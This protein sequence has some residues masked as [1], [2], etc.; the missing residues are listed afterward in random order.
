MPMTAATSTRSIRMTAPDLTWRSPRVRLA[1]LDH[2]TVDNGCR[3]EILKGALVVTPAP[4]RSHMAIAARLVNLITPQLVTD[5][6]NWSMAIQP[7]KLEYE[8][9]AVTYQC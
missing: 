6:Q 2:V 4:R 1:D 8:T 9:D 3:Y 7:I 5:A